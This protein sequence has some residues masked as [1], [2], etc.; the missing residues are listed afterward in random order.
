MLLSEQ[1][2]CQ[3]GFWMCMFCAGELVGTALGVI[4]AA[5]LASGAHS[6]TQVRS[7]ARV[8]IH[9]LDFRCVKGRATCHLTDAACRSLLL[10]MRQHF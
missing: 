9:L 3:S 7:G 6:E 10:V 4:G 1:L 8:I 5:A 2:H